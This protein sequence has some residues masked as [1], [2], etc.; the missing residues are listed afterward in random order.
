[1]GNTESKGFKQMGLAGYQADRVSRIPGTHKVSGRPSRQAQQDTKQTASAGYPAER[2][3]RIPGRQ[4][5]WDRADT[6][7]RIPSRWCQQVP[8]R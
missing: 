2:I 5:E 7:N 3:R 1:M 6:A 4:Y 8:T